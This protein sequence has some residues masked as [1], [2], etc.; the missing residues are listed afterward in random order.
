MVIFLNKMANLKIKIAGISIK[1]DSVNS[2]WET[3]ALNST[4]HSYL[5]NSIDGISINRIKIISMSDAISI[6]NDSVNV[7]A[8]DEILMSDMDSG[9]VILTFNHSFSNGILEYQAIGST[10]FDVKLTINSIV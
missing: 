1:E 2:D 10:I 9:I 7:N 3:H 5:S 8:G 6:A 4:L